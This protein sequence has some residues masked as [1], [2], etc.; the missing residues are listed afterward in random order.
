MATATTTVAVNAFPTG[1]DETGRFGHLY[2]TITIGS[3]GTYVTNGLPV[4]WGV[5]QNV[6][7]DAPF[8]CTAFSLSTGFAYAYDATHNTLRI[9]EQNATTGGLAE[10]ANAASVTADTL[11]FH[12]TFKRVN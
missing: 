11:Q 6:F 4:T 3:G 7:A 8:F 2:G 1:V 5:A 9:F 12:A 10:L